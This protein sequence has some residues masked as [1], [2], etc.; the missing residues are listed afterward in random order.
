MTP[1]I[2]E[3]GLQQLF[4][5]IYITLNIF[6]FPCPLIFVSYL[7]MSKILAIVARVSQQRNRILKIEI[8]PL[9]EL[10]RNILFYIYFRTNICMINDEQELIPA[11]EGTL[12]K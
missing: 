7:A 5:P 4:R 11:T 12:L 9:R 1:A 2:S 10:L 3:Y 6:T 8:Q